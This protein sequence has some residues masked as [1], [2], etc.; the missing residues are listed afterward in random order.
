[1]QA[2]A[3]LAVARDA[4]GVDRCVVRRSMPPLTLRP[5]PGEVQLVGSAAGPLGGDELTLDVH[6]RPGAALVLRSV[7]AMMAMPGRSGEPSRF[8]LDVRVDAGATLVWNP[9]P[10]I[11]VAGC[12]HHTC[13][14]VRLGP[15]AGVLWREELVLGR[16]GEA[17]GSLRQ[18]LDVEL[19]DA[20][21]AG[22]GVPLVRT[23]V[24][25]GP[26]Y[27]GSEGPAGT[28]GARAVGSLLL[29]GPAVAPASRPPGAVGGAFPDVRLEVLEPAGSALL[30]SA[31]APHPG[32]LAR[33][34]DELVARWQPL[35]GGG[36]RHS[37][38]R[39]GHAVGS[40]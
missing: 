6:V 16:F 12:D 17:S 34:F 7:A 10:T 3:S 18:R 23:E 35:L 1:M 32:A 11:A 30:V 20:G 14:R 5:T 36:S 13:T 19:L 26:R 8:D 40:E 27:P 15:G 38:A 22:T 39:A 9:Q 31:V 24:V 21:G 33:A 2:R 28:G 25:V 4:G 29:A 37:V